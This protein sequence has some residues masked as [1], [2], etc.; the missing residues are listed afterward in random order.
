MYVHDIEI[1]RGGY[2]KKLMQ[3]KN[4]IVKIS[5]LMSLVLRHNPATIGITL[6]E[7]G[8]AEVDR[9][10]I[11]I[12]EK[13]IDLDKIL[14]DE[15]VETNNKKRFA[16]NDD[17]TKIRASQGHSIAVDVELKAT[18]PPE[19]LYHGTVDRFLKAIMQ[20]GLKRMSRQH[21]HL[22]HELDT[23]IDVGNRRGKPVILIVDAH[24]MYRDGISFFLSENG[25]W[26]VDSVLPK[27]IS[28]KEG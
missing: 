5:K 17:K 18:V 24:R 14:L 15:I 12:Q 8:W 10:L 22:S 9:L 16:Y 2:K 3:M 28:K 20:E 21:V 7:N 25:V 4:K 23:A 11:G 19:K 1:K 13:G 27:Y 6:D 26:L